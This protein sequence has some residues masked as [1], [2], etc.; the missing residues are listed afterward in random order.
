MVRPV[1]R[2]LNSGQLDALRLAAGEGGGA[3]PEFDVAEADIPQ[4]VELGADARD[5]FEKGWPG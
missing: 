2:L 4:G 5:V 3:L 1:A